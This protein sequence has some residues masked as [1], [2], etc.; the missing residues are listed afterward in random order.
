MFMIETLRYSNQLRGGEGAARWWK[1]QRSDTK[2]REARRQVTIP[3]R[4]RSGTLWVDVCIHNMSSRG[5]LV[6]SEHPPRPGDYV[7][8]RRGSRIIIGRVVWRKG[9]FFGV[10]AQDVLD[11]DGFVSEPRL[12]SR[13]SA[14]RARAD[15]KPDR[16]LADR[17]TTD[18]DLAHRLERSR[19]RASAMQFILIAAGASAIAGLLATAVYDVLARPFTTIAATLSPDK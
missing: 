16:R 19:H 3:S 18:A 9:R 12:A 17:V 6:A 10:R 15:A 1:L 8:I 13:P 11:V 14:D 7:D 4:M 5:L 2:P